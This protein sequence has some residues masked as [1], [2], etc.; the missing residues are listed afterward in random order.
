[1]KCNKK[2]LSFLKNTIEIKTYDSRNIIK[3]HSNKNVETSF[4]PKGK[5]FNLNS[6]AVVLVPI[7]GSA[8]V[9]ENSNSLLFST[10]RILISI[11]KSPLWLLQSDRCTLY[12]VLKSYYS[13]RFQKQIDSIVSYSKNDTIYHFQEELDSLFDCF[14]N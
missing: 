5:T 11:Q 8:K 6:E 4:I 13:F 7:T 12:K 14:I 2:R 10:S 9:S 3:V 1:M